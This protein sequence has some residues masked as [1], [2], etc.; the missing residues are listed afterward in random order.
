MAKSELTE[1][2][3][4]S[5]FIRP[6]IEKAGWLSKTQIREEYSLTAGRILVRGQKATRDKDGIRRA[7][8]VLEYRR[9][10]PLAVVEAKDSSHSLEDG[11]QQAIDYA[12]RLGLPFAFS[13]NGSGFLFHDGTVDPKSGEPVERRLSL[14]EFPGP[15]A[16]WKKYRE[17]K[18]IPAECES[19]VLWN[20]Y[21]EAGGRNPR[22]YQVNA[23]NRS[24]EAISRG[25]DR[26]L[27]VM[28]T[29]T[30]KTY[31]A[32]QIIWRLWKSGR[33]K[34]ILYL[35]DRNILINQTMVND[36][37][38]FKG[39]MAKLSPKS[40]GMEKADIDTALRF[41]A[42][43]ADGTAYS[44]LVDYS[45]EIYLSLYQAVSGVEE[46]SNVYKQFKPDFFDLVIVDE[47]HRGS[48]AEESAWRSI[49]EYFSSAV[50]LG[51]TATPSTRD[52]ADN[53]RYFGEPVYEYS[54]KQGIEDG[55]LAPYKVIRVA[56]DRDLGWRP[57]PGQRDESGD[58]VEDREYN[59]KDMNTSL[60]LRER[61]R[62]VAKRVTRFLKENDRFAKTIVFCE[63]I[64]HAN[65]MR[66]ALAN[67]NADLVAATPKYVMKITGDDAEGKA[68]L[69]NFIDP[70]QPYPVIACTSRLMST[71]VDAKTCRLIVLDRSIGSMTEFK[72]IIGRG[73][74][75]E[76]DYGKLFFT[77]M[78]FKQATKLF[79]DPAFD[80][81]PA[82]ESEEDEEYG[83]GGQAA[84]GEAPD[85]A[86]GAAG[87]DEGGTGAPNAEQPKSF[88]PATDA[89]GIGTGTPDGE[90]GPGGYG[91]GAGAGSRVGEEV[92]E[93]R[94][95]Y[96]VAG[97]EVRII[98]ELVQYLDTAGKLMT[99]S[100]IDFS[101]RGIL[102]YYPV[103]EAFVE[104]WREA[105]RKRMVLDELEAG[106]VSIEMLEEK[107][108]EG[109]DPFDL[110]CHVAYGS[111]V[112]TRKER[113]EKAARE[114]RLRDLYSRYG[115]TARK[116]IET[117]L[118][119]YAQG[120]LESIEDP[121]VL[122]VPPFT[123]LGSVVEIYR[124]LGGREGYERV[125][126]DLESAIYD[127]A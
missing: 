90:D 44:K 33:A 32:F 4:R 22:Y 124:S 112:L 5:Q 92:G 24:L 96:Y 94:K 121:A 71:G 77:I 52:G 113:A 45:Y 79:A 46:A 120:G 15:E 70:E 75:I 122:K 111:R 43:A 97:V 117:L 61:D 82:D 18:R 108:G 56:L 11:I 119:K 57:E 41:A 8:Y 107:F 93:P 116:I 13:S 17:W 23:I 81:E 69:D 40:K 10:V 114:P 83:D 80:G 63:N 1:A 29:G 99:E 118:E 35:A 101:K 127:I 103:R 51:L 100:I 19:L 59:Q 6:A 60:V 65:R 98:N 30:G 88:R 7:D 21:G 62:I 14:D 47:C 66:V 2:E 27:L 72:Q 110:L 67:E 106:G 64:D 25:Q 20:Y 28:A 39:A 126:R 76:E 53:T 123:E 68:E 48:A 95:K 50:Q 3:T 109:L 105:D 91:R 36:F 31:T 102:K 58:L 12:S 9:N 54:L 34:R 84:S 16:L 125:V 74:R 37:K 42:E 85:T 87:S 26:I 73:T 89:D 55:Y 78:D 86:P 115:D 49:L 104:K 38:P